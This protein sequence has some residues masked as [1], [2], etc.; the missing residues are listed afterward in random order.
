M[1]KRIIKIA[2][3]HFLILFVL[4]SCFD[5]ANAETVS[6]H[7]QSELILIGTYAQYIEDSD[8]DYSFEFIKSKEAD[9]LWQTNK[10][11]NIGFGY[12]DSVYWVKVSVKNVRNSSDNYYFEIGYPVLDYIDV[13]VQS[14]G[15]QSDKIKLGDKLPF[16]S[17][18]V[19]HRNFVFPLKVQ[20]YETLD[21]YI[22]AK[23][24]SAVQLPM[25][26]YEEHVFLETGEIHVVG[27][28]FYYGAMIIM[29]IYNLFIFAVIREKQFL[30]YVI[31]VASLVVFVSSLNG[32]S[33]QFLWPESTWW[34]DQVIILSLGSTAFFV[35]LF[36][37]DFLRLAESM[38]KTYLFFLT[39]MILE[40]ITMVLSIKLS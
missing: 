12:T 17:R 4:L 36:S 33:F 3:L 11:D 14:M 25:R 9:N 30:Y 26:I 24:S 7:K 10:K 13:Y 23:S 1:E 31:Y 35:G 32:I 39:L 28:G 8:G 5:S 19:K 6:L 29:V 16:N 38:R 34:N 15:G 18:P 40:F 2:T 22:R 37:L 21:I 27:L 20:P